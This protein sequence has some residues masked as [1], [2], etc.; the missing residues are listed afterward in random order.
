MDEPETQVRLK[1]VEATMSSPIFHD[2]AVDPAMAADVAPEW[3]D[4]PGSAEPPELPQIAISRR[5][6]FEI[7]IIAAVAIAASFLAGDARAAII[8]GAFGLAALGTRLID[9]HVTFSFG[10]GF[11]GYRSDLGWPHGV[12]E[13]DDVHWNWKRST[14]R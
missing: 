8:V 2:E 12:Q 10:A 14:P 7:A 3:A 1:T 5:G 13:D 11:I 6:E 9:R 4:V